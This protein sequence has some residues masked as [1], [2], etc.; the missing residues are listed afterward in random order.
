MNQYVRA[1]F[2]HLL[3]GRYMRYSKNLE[4]D[5]V[6][7]VY[8]DRAEVVAYYPIRFFQPL[9][10]Q[11]ELF[12][13]QQ[14]ETTQVKDLRYLFKEDRKGR[15]TL[16]LSIIRQQHGNTWIYKRYKKLKHE[17]NDHQPGALKTCAEE[18]GSGGTGKACHP[19][20]FQLAVPGEWK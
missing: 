16:N 10:A 13:E 14:Q 8:N 19:C 1:C 5:E 15:I 12:G 3:T 6:F 4:G 11:A 20:N 9:R 2:D 18:T 17:K 7:K